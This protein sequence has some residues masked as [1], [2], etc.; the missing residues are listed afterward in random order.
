MPDGDATG[1][2]RVERDRPP[3]GGTQVTTGDVAAFVVRVLA[4]GTPLG[5][6]GIAG[7]A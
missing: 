3:D 2:A 4:D 1:R 6:V 5:R 7:P